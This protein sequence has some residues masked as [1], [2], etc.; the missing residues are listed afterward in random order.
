MIND[1]LTDDSDE[2]VAIE[3]S[4]SEDDSDEDIVLSMISRS[5]KAKPRPDFSKGTTSPLGKAGFIPRKKFAIDADKEASNFFAA[6][7]I[8]VSK[9]NFEEI[10]SMLDESLL[11]TIEKENKIAQRHKEN[12]NKIA[13]E[14]EKLKRKKELNV[15]K[16]FRLLNDIVTEEKSFSE[17]KKH[18]DKKYQIDNSINEFFLQSYL[19]ISRTHYL[20]PHGKFS[21]SFKVS[22]VKQIFDNNIA[23]NKAIVIKD[24]NILIQKKVST[25]GLADTIISSISQ[26]EA[27]L[28]NLGIDSGLVHD[29][30][31]DFK[32][33]DHLVPMIDG[34]NDDKKAVTID[35]FGLPIKNHDDLNDIDNLDLKTSQKSKRDHKMIEKLRVSKFKSSIEVFVNK[36]R[37]LSIILTRQEFFDQQIFDLLLKVA[38]TCLCDERVIYFNKINDVVYLIQE[39]IFYLFKV[40]TGAFWKSQPASASVGLANSRPLE[41]P[42]L[43]QSDGAEDSKNQTILAN[44]F[45]PELRHIIDIYFSVTSSPRAFYQMTQGLFTVIPLYSFDGTAATNVSLWSQFKLFLSLMIFCENTL[46]LETQNLKQGYFPVVFENLKPLKAKEFEK[47]AADDSAIL[48][49]PAS[50]GKLSKK[51][52]AFIN[53]DFRDHVI[54]SIVKELKYLED[55]KLSLSSLAFDDDFDIEEVKDILSSRG[56]GKNKFLK[57]MDSGNPSSYSDMKERITEGSVSPYWLLCKFMCLSNL[58]I[59]LSSEASLDNLRNGPL[60]SEFQ[61]NSETPQSAITA[62]SNKDI[63]SK[64]EF[65]RM[66]IDAIGISLNVIFNDYLPHSIPQDLDTSLTFLQVKKLILHLKNIVE[67]Y[68]RFWEFDTLE[69]GY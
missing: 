53:P 49:A 12:E 38:F 48:A 15:V 60:S 31:G 47:S 26:L 40:A 32:I 23:S 56:E 17:T 36:L 3:N 35:E 28:I 6:N 18:N 29:L 13:K 54:W 27:C 9:S 58:L 16:V 61:D 5:V 43:S 64:L 66:T 69:I 4:T 44:F 55:H 7:N 63:E 21:E 33:E 51:S 14:A 46:K 59:D 24:N 2:I 8:N 30:K 20:K 41:K 62:N 19:K 65:E 34:E 68:K 45:L 22:H 67:N 52:D 39:L 10:N 1:D 42:P 11:E 50:N 57:E 37:T 25:I